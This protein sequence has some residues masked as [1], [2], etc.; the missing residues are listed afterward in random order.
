MDIK[1]WQAIIYIVLALIIGAAAG[2]F[3]ARAW[4][5]NYLKK[6]PPVNE[7][8]I[9]EMMRQMGRTPSEKQVRQVMSSMNQV[10]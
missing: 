8:M 10:K 3:I 2:F 4:F 9:R 7:R 1:L 6:N 5:K